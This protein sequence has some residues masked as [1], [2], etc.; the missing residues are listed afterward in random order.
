MLT[1]FLTGRV[2]RLLFRRPR[3]RR[4]QNRATFGGEPS[5][6]VRGI[7]RVRGRAGQGGRRC[8]SSSGTARTFVGL[9]GLRSRRRHGHAVAGP[10]MSGYQRLGRGLEVG[11][12]LMVLAVRVAAATS[13][14]SLFSHRLAIV[15]VLGANI[16]SDP[17][18][19]LPLET[20]GRVLLGGGG[21]HPHGVQRRV[22]GS[23]ILRLRCC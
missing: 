8:G 2:A 17:V 12:L 11:N 5:C 19:V 21:A 20:S 7:V 15:A 10:R 4:G 14:F 9:S 18:V 6:A 1:T 16:G 3:G 13:Y 23:G 22:E